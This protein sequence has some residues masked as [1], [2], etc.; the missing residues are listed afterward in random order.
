MLPL[1]NLSEKSRI[2]IDRSPAA[3]E[4]PGVFDEYLQPEY[5]GHDT[6]FWRLLQMWHDRSGNFTPTGISEEGKDNVA[7]LVE[8]YGKEPA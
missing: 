5:R 8:M 4:F 7:Q 6:G 3:D 1:E 2:T